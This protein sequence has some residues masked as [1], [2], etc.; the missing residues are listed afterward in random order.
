MISLLEVINFQSWK[1]GVFHLHQGVNIFVGTSDSGKSSIVRAFDW[2]LKNNKPSSGD[3]F[4]SDW[5]GDTKIIAHIDDHN[6]IRKKTNT[7]NLYKLDKGTFKAFGQ[8]TPEEVDKLVNLSD[9]NWQ[10]QHDSPFLL[11]KTPGEVARVLNEIVHLEKIDSSLTAATSKLRSLNQDLRTE[12]EEVTELRAKLKSFSYL[13]DMEEE[14]SVL[15]KIEKKVTSLDSDKIVL[16]TIL[17]KMEGMREEL[18]EANKILKAEKE[19]KRL[20][21]LERELAQTKVQRDS[22]LDAIETM[23]SGTRYISS[24]TEKLKTMEKEWTKNM[25]DECPLC[26]RSG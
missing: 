20:V 24:R 23:N 6:L 9:I 1:R 17:E 15:A 21:E 2:V 13:D 12:E 5:G 19:V 3:A 10:R 18:E 7:K 14:I 11:S 4:R 8:G 22:L 25:P 26:G 16:E